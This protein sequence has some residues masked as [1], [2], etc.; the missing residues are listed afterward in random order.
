MKKKGGIKF[1]YETG[2]AEKTLKEFEEFTTKMMEE[3][4]KAFALPPEHVNC[5]CSIVEPMPDDDDLLCFL[6]LN[7]AFRKRKDVEKKC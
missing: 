2:E 6:S 5:H 1:H 3:I 4:Y 7:L